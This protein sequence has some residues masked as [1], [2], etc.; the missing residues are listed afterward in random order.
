MRNRHSAYIFLFLLM[1]SEVSNAQ[2]QQVDFNPI[3][4]NDG[5]SLGKINSITQ[6]SQG[7]I[8][9][10]DQDNGY[11]IRY[12]GLRMTSYKPDLKNP[13]SLG[14]NYPEYLFADST[15]ILWIGFYGTGLDRFD[16][17]T[18]NFTHFRYKKDDPSSL[19]SDTVASVL[20]DHDG[21]LWVGTYGGLNLLDQKTGKFT[22]FSHSESD[23][24]SLSCNK[25]RAIYEDRKKTLWIGTGNPFVGNTDGG[26]NRFDPKTGKFTRFMHDPSDPNS[27]IN[28]KV[29]AI[30]EDSRGTF[31]IGAAGTDGLLTMDRAK[32]T[33]IRH[34]YNPQ[35]PD[36]LSR[37]PVKE[38]DKFDHITFITEDGLGA[39]WIG[40]FSEGILKY[41]PAKQILTRFYG[42]GNKSSGFKDQSGWCTL[43]SKDGVIWISTQE[44]NLYRVDP[45]RNT[46]PHFKSVPATCFYTDSTNVL[47]YGTGNEGLFCKDSKTGL[48]HQFKNDPHDNNSLISNRVN[49]II[50]E[51]GGDLWISMWTGGL[52]RMDKKTKKLTRYM[53]DPKNNKSLISDNVV[54]I[55]LDREL[56]LWCG[57]TDGCDVLDR[58]T[59]FFKHYLNNP[60][61]TNSISRSA[62][63]CFLEDSKNNFWVGTWNGGGIN[64]L[65][66][67]T[68][69]FKHYLF[70]EFVNSI[71]EDSKGVIWVGTNSGLFQYDRKT[72]RFS[73]L[74]EKSIGFN[75]PNAWGIVGDNQNNLWFGSSLGIIRLSENRDKTIIYGK[76]NGVTGSSLSWKSFLGNNGEIYFGNENGYFSFK[77]EE[78]NFNAIPPVIS[79]NSFWINGKP[80][81]PVSGGPFPVPLSKVKSIDLGYDQNV[82]SFGLTAIDYG[83]PDDNRILYQL[84]GSD[85]DWNILGADGRASYFNVPPGKY[86]L[87]IKAIN[88]NNGVWAEKSLELIISPP[89]WK[90][91]VAYC[92]YGLLFIAAVI[93][94]DRFQ[95]RRLL[96]AERERNRD[97]ELAQAKEIEKAYTELKTTQTQLIQ[98]EKMASLG[99]LTAGIAHEIQNPLNFVNN[100]SEVNLELIQEM[101]EEIEKG[102]LDEV[103]ALSNDI[104]D[105]EQKINHHG[106]RADSIV[107]GMLQ[108]SRSSSG[109]KEPTNINALADEYLR[110]AY[111]G[112]RAKDKSFNATMKTDFDESI[113]KI[114]IIPQ[115]IG[116]VILN[117][118]NNA[119][120]AAPLPPEGG[121]KDPNYIHK[122]TVTV[123]TS[124]IPPSG[125]SRGAV[126]ISVRDNGPGIPPKILDKI[127]QPFFTTKPTGE[128]TGLGLSM[129]YDIITKVHGGELK[130]ETK[131]GEGAE[132]TIILPVV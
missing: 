67:K 89:F 119:F 93:G 122:P 6:D 49:D 117:L 79:I 127:F 74:D 35:K 77:A 48:I 104:A 17:E 34:P 24:A 58:K 26:L 31:W 13:N 95:R 28:N 131:E 92:L 57:T 12:D 129:S 40:T 81:K 8:W 16:P 53:H 94:I 76:K 111:H 102:N 63:T 114:N 98:A 71:F 126:L 9:L 43:V 112:L 130:V 32:G 54:T 106:K 72:D 90:T 42:D 123:K 132:F 4:G 37:P 97:R 10:S 85:R 100:F 61:D 75:I 33:F 116:R 128:G 7:Y 80:I 69:Q 68:D 86:N 36:Q 44:K 73:L 41:D 120:Y 78:L 115:D 18:G 87:R 45:Y 19:S 20:M 107:K 105:N 103:K 2:I 5:I 99:E 60:K 110:L 11:I 113:G 1:L 59:G 56:N 62:T 29:R 22:R 52:N 21:N 23:P 30:F 3:L 84:I 14:G 39:I 101:K 15:G 46:I 27:L 55:Y 118:I 65:D 50:K 88:S 109:V 51:P 38:G 82:F 64:R 96:E 83:N 121:F 124:F 108:H 125:G 25:I 91:W 47:W 70:D 66:R